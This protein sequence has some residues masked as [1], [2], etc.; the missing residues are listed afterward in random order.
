MTLDKAK[1]NRNYKISAIK[2]DDVLV[3]TRCFQF[4]MNLGATIKVKRRAPIFKD[5]LLIEV[6]GCQVAISKDHAI[7]I[8]VEEV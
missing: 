1:L 6:D 8:E 5:P 2:I 4:G 7:A 3:Q